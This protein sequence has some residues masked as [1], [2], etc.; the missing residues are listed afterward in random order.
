MTN[1]L[2][3]P[4]FPS[5]IRNLKKN[6]MLIYETFSKGN[7]KYGHPKNLNFLLKSGELLRI[8]EKKLHVIAFEEGYI[9]NPKK[10]V[11]QRICAKKL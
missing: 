6:G 4:L 1:Y 11:V 9:E 7:E 10:A 8:V 2:F 3:R 5:I